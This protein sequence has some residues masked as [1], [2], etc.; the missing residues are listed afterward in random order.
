[1]TRRKNC[2]THMANPRVI[3]RTIFLTRGN[4]LCIVTSVPFRDVFILSLRPAMDSSFAGDESIIDVVFRTMYSRILVA[5][6]GSEYARRGGRIAL[7]LARNIG[8]TLL[9]CHVYGA[10]LHNR[11]FRDMEPGLSSR[12]LGAPFLNELRH[13]HRSL[14][15]DG[16]R[17]LSRGYMEDYLTEA[18]RAG[19]QVREINV[20]GRNYVRLLDIAR[21]EGAGLM[22]LGAFGT[23]AYDP[24][25]HTQ[26]FK[27]MA[28]SVPA[29]RIEAI[30]LKRQEEVHDQI[31][32][33]GLGTLYSRFLEKAVQLS[34][35]LGAA[36]TSGL[37]RGKAYRALVDQSEMKNACLTVVGRFGHH[38][39]KDSWIGSNAEA[40]VRLTHNN[41]L[42][43]MSEQAAEARSDKEASA[44]EWDSEAEER[45]MRIPSPA[46]SMAKTVVENELKQ[47]GEGRVTLKTF[48]EIARRLGMGAR[49]DAEDG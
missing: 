26:L 29:E 14:I 46:R 21:Q 39:E 34:G 45:L 16:L 49:P 47:R 8:A 40:L 15:T 6:D 33:D 5:L 20:E 43:C 1:M 30:G 9:A 12:Y 36:A 22:V 31:I 2:R 4:R 13:T 48:L 24:D 11:R 41:V 17:A 28:C 25:F 32:N 27:S 7:D 37:V 42:V 44:F 10:E 35:S 3:D 18:K 23:A 38:R 19:V